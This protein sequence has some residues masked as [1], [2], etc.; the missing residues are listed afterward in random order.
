M[1]K[2]NDC[3]FLTFVAVI[4]LLLF[5]L[6]TYRTITTGITYDEAYTYM[7]YVSRNPFFV[8]KFMFIKGTYANHHILNS[9]LISCLQS[10]INTRYSEIMIRIPNV[11]FY[12]IYLLFSY[13][14][15]KDYK[16]KYLSFSLLVFNY[17]FN[18]FFGLG[19]GYG[20]GCALVLASIY[21]FKKFIEYDKNKD[22]TLTYIF[23]LLSCYANT[24]ALI[25][26]LSII[27]VSFYVLIKRKKFFK[28]SFNQWYF[29]IPIIVL[30]LLVVKYHFMV[31]SDGLPLYGG[32]GS[33]YSDVLVSIFNTIGFTTNILNYVVNGVILILIV[34]ISINF[35]KAKENYLI[36]SGI[37][38][39]ILLIMITKVTKSI[40]ITGRSLIPSIPLFVV[41]IIEAIDYLKIK[42]KTIF[43]LIVS[44]CLFTIFCLN[45]N[46]KETREWQDNYILRDM[47]YEAFVTK[48]N[49]N[50]IKYKDNSAAIFY[51]EKIL[52]YR[53]YDIFSEE[54]EK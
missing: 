5:S 32:N 22:L 16:Y 3:Y 1:K 48:D 12:L 15:C 4:S 37:V 10:I 24:V 36:I 30:T 50:I 39:F 26:F 47:A 49:S 33:F 44:V 6:T 28:Y 31:S 52:Y 9:F 51:R 7:N 29:L 45:L 54:K 19:R 43:E 34:I 38:Y 42:K 53:N 21:F 20:I 35:K 8:F 14:L 41:L 13:L 25:P 11:I 18:E 17:G 46:L 2:K 23:L 27:L 40:W